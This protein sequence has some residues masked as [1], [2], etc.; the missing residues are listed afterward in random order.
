[1]EPKQ[2]SVPGGLVELTKLRKVGETRLN[3]KDQ[4]VFKNGEIRTVDVRAGNVASKAYYQFLEEPDFGWPQ[5]EASE[6]YL[7]P[8]CVL[9]N[10]DPVY[11]GDTLIHISRNGYCF[12][13]DHVKVC[14]YSRTGYSIHKKTGRF[15]F[16]T[17]HVVLAT[18]VPTKTKK[19][20]PK[21]RWINLYEQPE[22]KHLLPGNDLHFS[23]KDAED[24]YD[25]QIV[26]G[27]Y[28]SIGSFKIILEAED[29]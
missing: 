20:K 2:V 8:L 27:D 23:K 6:A 19:P 1:V 22:T 12:K 13:A 29:E 10:G 9:P 24:S 3:V 21:F 15:G 16:Y 26:A 25:C 7:I 28:V 17:S 11:K 14:D 5:K 4:I 18:T